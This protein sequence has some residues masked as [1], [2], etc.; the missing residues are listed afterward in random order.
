MPDEQPK[1]PV[2]MGMDLATGPV[3]TVVHVTGGRRWGKTTAMKDA[4][5]RHLEAGHR[6]YTNTP[7]GW[8]K[9]VGVVDDP[10][11]R[12]IEGETEGGD[13]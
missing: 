13:A 10:N 8:E 7:S 12:L 4:V 6:V 5:K 9:V 1:P 3:T 2:W 11:T